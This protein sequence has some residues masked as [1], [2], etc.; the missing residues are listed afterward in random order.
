MNLTL[1]LTAFCLGNILSFWLPETGATWLKSVLMLAAIANVFLLRNSRFFQAACVGLCLILGANYA[2]FRTQIALNQQYPASL[3]PAQEN[4]TV[5]VTGLPEI[6]ETRTRFIG[7]ARTQNG[8]NY[9]ILFQDFHHNDWQIGDTW[10]FSTRIRAPIGLKNEVGFDR[11]AWALA[12]QIDGIASVSKNRIQLSTPFSFFSFNQLRAKIR[13]NNQHFAQ[14]YPQGVALINA[15]AIGDKS[16]LSA[17]TWAALRPLGLN[18]LISI[19]GL[20]IGMI[21]AWAMWLMR[22]LLFFYPKTPVLPRAWSL[23]FG[24]LAAAFYTGL[25][26]FETPALRSLIMLMVFAGAWILG[27]RLGSWQTWW[28]AMSVVLLWQ[29]MAILAVGFWLSFGLVAAL[30][31]VSAFRLHEPQSWLRT[32]FRTQ[33]AA[34]VI[35]SLASI[36]WFGLL[37][38]FSPLAN[39]LAI[40]FFSFILTPLAIVSSILPFEWL[41]FLTIFLAQHTVEYLVWAGKILP[42]LSFAHAPVGLFLLAI[43]SAMIFLLPNAMRLYPL[44]LCALLSFLLYRPAPISGSLNAVVWDVGQGLSIL[45][46]T[47][48]HTILFDTGTQTATEMAL[49]PNLRARGI[50]SLDWVILSHHDDDHDGGL[51]NLQKSFSIKQLY[52]GQPSFYPQAQYCQEGINWT[53]D[54]VFFEFLTANFNTQNDND[55]SCVLRVIAGETALLITGDISHR[56]EKLL[57][58]KYGTNLNSQILILAH[59]GSKSSNSSTFINAVSPQI[60]IA[61]SGFANAF[62]HPHPD[63]QNR[64][65]AHRVQLLR[66]DTQGAIA[67][68]VDEQDFQAAPLILHPYWWQKKPFIAL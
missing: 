1:A 24:I 39:A 13:Q 15:L 19:S 29:P 51:T 7:N 5:T 35:G 40:P 10:Q 33:Y 18:H 9:R 26:G 50:K 28:L 2:I 59:H 21:A 32:F 48:S 62:H 27:K 31:W 68:H 49:L 3:N 44:A 58:E 47:R 4:L 25:S 37:P 60:A 20:H 8:K 43:L 55:K 30:I 41:Q 64:L 36:Y 38:V 14:Q 57:V 22:F 34:T 56:A 23:G 52:A 16:G 66:T 46:Q 45:L 67:I 53:I 65:S 17:E 42:E 6:D 63:V 61:S 54:G 12:N 11:E